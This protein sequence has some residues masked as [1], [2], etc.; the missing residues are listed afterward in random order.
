MVRLG[1]ALGQAVRPS[2]RDVEL[3]RAVA[4]VRALFSAAACSCALVDANGADLRFV[5]ADGQGADEIVGVTLSAGAGIAG[6]AVMSG[7][8]IVVS[9]VS[10]DSRFARDVAE[11]T[12]Y[13]PETI[14]ASPLVDDAGE[15]L[16]VIEV[17]DPNSRGEHSGHDLDVLGVA[18]SMVASIVRLS[19][20]YDALGSTMIAG[21]VGAQR[22]EAVETALAHMS[23]TEGT[24]LSGLARVFHELASSGP[25]AL[26]LAE[27]VL[28]EVARFARTHR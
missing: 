10:S 25:E 18:A 20:V 1:D 24:D 3:R 8:P 22:G 12:R 15:V 27:R 5:A 28:A 11:S 2:S 26:R 17:L 6:W 7:Q 19:G 23:T 14:L 21:L 9:D 13:V 4:G 16:G